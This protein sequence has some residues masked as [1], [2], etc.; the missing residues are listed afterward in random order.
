MRRTLM[1][2]TR[3]HLP[4]LILILLVSLYLRIK[5]LTA[6]SYWNDELATIVL[7]DPDNSLFQ[8]VVDSLLDKSPPLYQILLWSWFNL[9]DFTEIAG[10][11]LSAIFGVLAV[12]AIYFMARDY[13]DRETALYA[14]LLTG[15]NYFHIYYSQEVRSYGLFFLFTVLSLWCL[16]RLIRE[17]NYRNLIFYTL[18]AICL[19]QVHY[20]G[21][22]IYLAQF[23]V[24]I[25]FKS[26]N[27]SPHKIPTYHLFINVFTI[28][29]SMIPVIPFMVIN[30]LKDSVWIKTPAPD[31]LQK[32]F[33]EYFGGDAISVVYVILFFS[34][35]F[36]LFNNKKWHKRC[37]AYL[38]IFFLLFVYLLPYFKS[39]FSTPMIIPRYTIAGLPL[40]ILIIAAGITA[41]KNNLVKTLTIIV[42]I[43]LS[44]KVLFF[45]KHYYGNVHKQQYRQAID[46]VNVNYGSVPLYACKEIRVGKYYKMLGYPPVSV[47]ARNEMLF[48]LG[49]NSVPKRFLYI[50]S[51]CCGCRESN[52][53]IRHYAH[54][55]NYT[56]IDTKMKGGVMVYLM[57][58]A[59]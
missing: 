49:N 56:L 35:L 58:A 21:V 34:G 38:A 59:D 22:L 15:L 52:A 14:S 10:R 19:V 39:L 45:D 26:A 50:S 24:L 12:P 31:F 30:A 16:S 41:I 42:V 47:G 40:I 3:L 18:S 48:Q 32:Y 11:L 54:K 13:T 57:S 28:L 20:Y 5:G 33:T 43:S 2:P 1:L 53:K 6:Q 9:F 4:W 55:Y 37:P 7:T 8:V 29:I 46:Y 27:K 44:A 51:E 25:I 17:S 23:I 36:F